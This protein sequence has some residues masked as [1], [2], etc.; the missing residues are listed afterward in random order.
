MA[1]QL[2]LKPQVDPADSEY[3]FGK[4]RD[5]SNTGADDG[6]PVNTEVYGDFHQFFAK[7]INVGGIT[8]NNQPDN[9]YDGFQYYDALVAVINLGIY[10]RETVITAETWTPITLQNNWVNEG[11]GTYHDAEYYKDPF[12][13]VRV[14]GHIKRSDASTGSG[15]D[16]NITALIYPPS[17]EE[18]FVVFTSNANYGGALP[19]Y[20]TISQA[21]ILTPNP[22]QVPTAADPLLVLNA[23]NDY[24]CLDGISFRTV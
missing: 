18:H 20:I 16:L 4:I 21:G 11:S 23:A 19:V 12:G 2:L 8:Y 17:K 3:P 24:L 22:F 5:D 15:V 7:I 6:T 10:A 13:V 1:I 14:R 9:A